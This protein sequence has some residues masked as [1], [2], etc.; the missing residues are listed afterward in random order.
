MR[1]KKETERIFYDKAISLFRESMSYGQFFFLFIDVDFGNTI[2]NLRLLK[3]D[4]SSKTQ[5]F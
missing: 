1:S 2:D 3:L 4:R 5:W